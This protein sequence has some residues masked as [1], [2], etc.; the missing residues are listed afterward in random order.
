MQN[1]Y[2]KHRNIQKYGGYF[3]KRLCLIFFW[4]SEGYVFN[5]RHKLKIP[6]TFLNHER[7]RMHLCLGIERNQAKLTTRLI[8]SLIVLLLERFE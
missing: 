1:Y 6:L 4:Q 8:L 5:P 3:K 7:E 2:R